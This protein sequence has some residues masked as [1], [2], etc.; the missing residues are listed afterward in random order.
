MNLIFKVRKKKISKEIFKCGK[1]KVSFWFGVH[2]SFSFFSK[3]KI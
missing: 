1:T 3:K 2:L